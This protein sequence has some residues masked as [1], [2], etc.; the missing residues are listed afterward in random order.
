M[1]P[2]RLRIDADDAGDVGFG[3]TIGGHRFDLTATGRFGLMRAAPMSGRLLQTALT[4]RPATTSGAGPT[5]IIVG[6]WS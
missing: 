1:L 4:L 3:N 2:K 5:S 6:R